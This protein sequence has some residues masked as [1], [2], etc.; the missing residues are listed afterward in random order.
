MEKLSNGQMEIE[1]RKEN[2]LGIIF[3]E[4]DSQRRLEDQKGSIQ[5]G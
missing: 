1:N 4:K 2:D 5:I 3:K